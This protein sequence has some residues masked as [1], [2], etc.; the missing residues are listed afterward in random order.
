LDIK[1]LVTPSEIDTK[2]STY[3]IEVTS[4]KN[5]DIFSLSPKEAVSPPLTPSYICF[6]A[7]C[8]DDQNIYAISRVETSKKDHVVYYLE[9]SKRTVGCKF[10]TS[11]SS[12]KSITYMP[13]P[14]KKSID[15][16]LD[17]PTS[18]IT[19]NIDEGKKKFTGII[20]GQGLNPGHSVN[21]VLKSIIDL[22][23]PKGIEFQEFQNFVNGEATP[24]NFADENEN[25]NIQI[26]VS[27]P[28][29]SDFDSS[30]SIIGFELIPSNE[31]SENIELI[32]G[33]MI[34]DKEFCALY[35][36]TREDNNSFY[37]FNVSKLPENCTKF[38]KFNLEHKIQMNPPTMD[39]I[40]RDVGNNEVEKVVTIGKN[41]Y[42]VRIK[43]HDGINKGLA[44]NSGYFNVLKYIDLTAH[45]IDSVVN[46]LAK[47]VNQNK[48][49]ETDMLSAF[50]KY[51]EG[52]ILSRPFDFSKD[53]LNIEITVSGFIDNYS[54][55]FSDGEK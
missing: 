38:N 10:T 36:I 25:L 31:A 8:I 21:S 35:K 29:I 22:Y 32:G 1:I 28:K 49:Y 6:Q 23:N 51:V 24:F 47:I 17:G 11:K 4:D 39:Y 7:G 15:E 42:S 5:T 13:P 33:K 9:I 53:D 44:E 3:N 40:K 48:Q 19:V 45:S 18:R 41:N 16:L 50:V 52:S 20:K 37:Y 30:I 43:G 14:T 12:A 46:A 55:S 26:L 54:K 34:T 2:S 27:V